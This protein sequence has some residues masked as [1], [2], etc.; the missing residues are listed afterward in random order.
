MLL[1]ICKSPPVQD[2]SPE[3]AKVLDEYLSRYL[4]SAFSATKEHVYDCCNA[5]TAM[6]VEAYLADEEEEAVLANMC[7]HEEVA[8]YRAAYDPIC[9][10]R[11]W[12]WSYGW[13]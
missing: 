8:S 5:L 2:E 11:N 13:H 1:H 10:A 7:K 9:F 12:E 4:T 6:D 3:T